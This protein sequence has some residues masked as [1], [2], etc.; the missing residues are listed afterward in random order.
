[1]MHGDAQTYG[2]AQILEASTADEEGSHDLDS[3]ATNL[4]Q[5]VYTW[6]AGGVIQTFS[7]ILVRFNSNLGSYHLYHCEKIT[8]VDLVCIL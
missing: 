5:L 8:L 7:K 2:L 4:S 3:A 6:L 1:M